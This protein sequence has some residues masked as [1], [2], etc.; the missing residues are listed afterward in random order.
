MCTRV[1]TVGVKRFLILLLILACIVIPMMAVQ[2]FIDKRTFELSR[3][4][5]NKAQ[6]EFYKGTPLHD[7]ILDNLPDVN[8]KLLGMSL[9][10]I[11]LNCFIGVSVIYLLT[12]P[13]AKKDRTLL[14]RRTVALVGSAYFLRIFTIL[15]TRLPS[16]IKDC[17]VEDFQGLSYLQRMFNISDS[18]SDMIYSGHTCMT[19]VL[20]WGW[21]FNSAPHIVAKIYACLHAFTAI[22]FFLLNR[23][24]YSVDITLGIY[25]TFFLTT[26]YAFSLRIIE[27]NDQ[28]DQHA[29]TT[30]KPSKES[31]ITKSVRWIE[32]KNKDL[33]VLEDENFELSSQ[34][35]TPVL[36]SV[37]EDKF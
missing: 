22:L 31:F 15:F 14:L 5:E 30:L 7:E 4:D 34:S 17:K 25:I 28:L 36:E 23:F 29:S 18:C 26:I 35:S 32:V 6:Q 3:Y 33:I 37:K 10:D 1:F 24:H 11:I 9:G 13:V 12:H 8:I 21:L 2:V 19:L 16:A 20:L 27:H